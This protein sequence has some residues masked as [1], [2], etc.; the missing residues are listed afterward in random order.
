MQA[1]GRTSM[2]N[3]IT[4]A[5]LRRLKRG[6]LL[7]ML[8]A[9]S[10]ENERLEA[11]VQ[12]LTA[13]LHSREIKL[14][15]AGSMAEAALQ[16]NGVFEAAQNAATQYLENIQQ[17]SRQQD[18][19]CARRERESQLQA[20]QLL[21]RTEEQCRLLERQTKATCDAMMSSAKAEVEKY[22]N[23]LSSRLE[24]FYATRQGLA[25][26]LAVNVKPT[27]SEARHEETE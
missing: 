26:M 12:Q 11:Q 1:G 4:D 10:K 3:Q 20:Q 17:R 13:Q 18:E 24:Q 23:D 25:E 6:D 22:W 9:S 8:L 16:L 27:H 14:E 21:Q 19:I 5:D 7:E 15:E 2:I